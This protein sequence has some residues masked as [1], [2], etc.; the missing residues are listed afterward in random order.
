MRPGTLAARAWD[1][2]DVLTWIA[3]LNLAFWFFTL[4]GGVVFGAAPS[5][6][7][8]ATLVRRRSNGD[9]VRPLSQFWAVYKAEFVRANALLLPVGL[10]VVALGFSCLYFQAGTDPLSAVLAGLAVVLLAFTLAA[11]AA[12]IP[13]YCSYDLPLAR[14]LAAAVRLSLANPLMMVL[15]LA[16]IAGVLALTWALPGILPFFT[17]G[18]LS[19]LG[20]RLTLDFI[21]R[22]EKRRLAGAVTV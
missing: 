13:V 12:L 19:Y 18:L 10:A 3:A 20:T 1:L 8:A 5:A 7:A 2:V 22:N 9:I 21:T 4:L 16:V 11:A 17:V 14:Y 6:V 15:N